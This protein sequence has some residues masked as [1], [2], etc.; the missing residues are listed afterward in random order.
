M[1][2]VVTGYPRSGTSM[3]MQA[4]AAGGLDAATDPRRDR[5]GDR[6]ATADYVPLPHGAW[7]LMP[8][9]YEEPGFPR[10]YEG[11][12]LKVPWHLAASMVVDEYRVVLMRRDP[13]EIQASV[14]RAFG[15]APR[16]SQIEHYQEMMDDVTALL[17]N[18]RDTALVELSYP[19]V[20]AQPGL[21]FQLLVREG[22][23][24][25]AD[26]AAA[27]VDPAL[28]RHRGEG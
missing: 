27:V 21:A 28:Y 18:R 22:W 20:V 8:G 9:A 19:H 24:I 14:R 15:H 25:D 11:R 13:R 12:L 4:L 5:M 6:H 23:P 17:R 10:G 3:M 26:S 7:E 2:Y 1:T 16:H